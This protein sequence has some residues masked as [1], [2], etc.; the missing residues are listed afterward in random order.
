MLSAGNEDF[1]EEKLAMMI[2][3]ESPYLIKI[4]RELSIHIIGFFNITSNVNS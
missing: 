3:K 1:G 4:N 2:S